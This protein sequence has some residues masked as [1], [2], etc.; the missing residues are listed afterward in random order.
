MIQ[1]ESTGQMDRPFFWQSVWPKKKIGP[2]HARKQ[3]ETIS[4]KPA[5]VEAEVGCVPKTVRQP[6]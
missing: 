3:S 6:D 5:A 2:V 4:R 1:S